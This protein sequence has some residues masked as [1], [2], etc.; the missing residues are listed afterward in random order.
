[1]WETILDSY[2]RIGLPNTKV[3]ESITQAPMFTQLAASVVMPTQQATASVTFTQSITVAA[4]SA[5]PMVTSPDSPI[6]P[7]DIVQYA[8]LLKSD[9]QPLSDAPQIRLVRFKRREIH[10]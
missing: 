5:Q 7:Q 3:A 10:Q 4:V 1:M 2:S 8:H 6:S 9:A